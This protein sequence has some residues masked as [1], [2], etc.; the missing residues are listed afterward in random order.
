MKPGARLCKSFLSL[1]FRMPIPNWQIDSWIPGGATTVAAQ[2]HPLT[3]S[4]HIFG[5]HGPGVETGEP[6]RNGGPV[7]VPEP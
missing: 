6:L 5:R 1:Y 7:A 2:A 4:C 3:I